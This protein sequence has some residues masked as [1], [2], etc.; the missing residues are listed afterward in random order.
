MY[1]VSMMPSVRVCQLS[2][3][4]GMQSLKIREKRQMTNATHLT[5]TNFRNS[6][7]NAHTIRVK[8][9]QNDMHFKS[10][11]TSLHEKQKFF[12]HLKQC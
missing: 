6:L 8:E 9:D 5:S 11:A 12:L 2:S 7:G 10:Y 4:Q 1:S 3:D